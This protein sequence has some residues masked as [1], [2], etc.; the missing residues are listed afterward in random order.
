MRVAS[1]PTKMRIAGPMKLSTNKLL[2]ALTSLYIAV[3]AHAHYAFTV[4]GT[5]QQTEAGYANGQSVN[6]TL[7]G[8]GFVN[9]DSTYHGSDVLWTEESLSHDVLFDSLTGT[10]LSGSWI[11]P[12]A[13]EDSPYS[14]L[15]LSESYITA[16]LFSDGNIPSGITTESGVIV[17]GFLIGLDTPAATFILPSGEPVPSVETVVA[18]NVGTHQ[19]SGTIVLFTDQGNLLFSATSVTFAATAIPEPSTYAAI[20]GGFALVGAVAYRRRQH[21]LNA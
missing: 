2:I 10:G 13:E 4:S 19:V 9:G 17:Y 8:S 7:S 11:R 12:S 16:F 15:M 20:F 21:A 3:S 6:F 14:Y 18:D 1:A 5:S